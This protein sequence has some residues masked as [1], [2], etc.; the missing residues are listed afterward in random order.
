MSHAHPMRIN[1]QLILE[2]DYDE[3]YEPTE[4][5]EHN[6]HD[7]DKTEYTQ[8]SCWKQYITNMYYS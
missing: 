3:N 6:K 2:E 1:D 4:E 8:V 5:G 7:K